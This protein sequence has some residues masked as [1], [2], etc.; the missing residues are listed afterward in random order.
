[1]VVIPMKKNRMKNKKHEFILSCCVNAGYG[2][3]LYLI[4]KFLGKFFSHLSLNI[5]F[6]FICILMASL[7]WRYLDP[8]QELSIRRP[9]NWFTRLPAI[10][11]FFALAYIV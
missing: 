8:Y 3:V 5:L 4:L 6:L 9:V 11:V 2:G 1:M 7:L 10:I